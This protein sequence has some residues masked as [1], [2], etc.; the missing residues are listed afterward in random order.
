MTHSLSSTGQDVL[1]DTPPRVRSS[2]FVNENLARH[3]PKES[4]LNPLGKPAYGNVDKPKALPTVPQEKQQK[5]TDDV[6]HK[7]ANLIRYRQPLAI[8]PAAC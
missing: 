2:N 3:Y 6:L 1:D 7:P 4:C 8:K 5:R